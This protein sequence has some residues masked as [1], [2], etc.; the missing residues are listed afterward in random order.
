MGIPSSKVVYSHLSSNLMP[1]LLEI[2]YEPGS[3]EPFPWWHR[4]IA[5]DDA[6]FISIQ[7]DSKATDEYSGGGFRI[8]VERATND[9]APNSKLTGRALFFQLLPQDL[10][11]RLLGRQNA[12]IGSLQKPPSS[13]VELYPPASRYQYLSYFEP[14]TGFDPIR[15]WLRYISIHDVDEWA[16]D[17]APCLRYL[18]CNA[19][20]A[21]PAGSLFR[22]RTP[23]RRRLRSGDPHCHCPPLRLRPWHFGKPDND[24][25]R[26][27]AVGV[28]GE[29]R[30]CRLP[31]F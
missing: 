31:R 7:V 6:V 24:S 17:I 3:K 8:E 16:S 21:G 26:P 14:Q 30:G 12:I 25:D 22:E 9:S 15:S 10:N 20:A 11:T 18:D 28:L 29:L 23:S 2:G 5:D 19:V 27:R 4:T 1:E 13:H